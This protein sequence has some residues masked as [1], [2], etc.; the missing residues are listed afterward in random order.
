MRVLL[1]G[2]SGFVGARVVAELAR[3]GHA[4]VGLTRSE[5]GART[6]AAAGGEPLLGDVEDLDRLAAAA[7]RADGVIHAAFDHDPAKQRRTAEID[8]RVVAT[9]GRALADGNRPLVVTSGTGLVRSR[10]GGSAVETADHLAPADHPPA[11]TEDAA[12]ALIEAGGRVTVLRL[13]QVHDARRQGRISWHVDLARERGRVAY[14][15]DG[16]NR[17]PAVHVSDAARL[18]RSALERGEAGARL[19]AV[20]E[21]GVALRDVAEAIGR[22]LGLPVVSLPPEQVDGYFGWLAPLAAAD[23][24]ASGAWTRAAFGWEPTGPDLLADLRDRPPS[25]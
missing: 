16:L 19:H 17:L 6:V 12:D 1:T 13:P 4:V 9:L 25:A 10:A 20:A 22:R 18:Y 11:A 14:V 24:P 3:A 23:L 5:A 7:A 8:A 15:G 21:E 2:A